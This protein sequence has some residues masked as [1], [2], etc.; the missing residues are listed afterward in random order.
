MKQ[1]CRRLRRR[2]MY[3]WLGIA[4]RNTD[5]VT[6][7]AGVTAHATTWESSAPATQDDAGKGGS[8]EDVGKVHTDDVEKGG[9]GE[10][11]EKGG[12]DVLVS[13]HAVKVATAAQDDEAIR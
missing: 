9:T 3:A 2:Y 12:T 4:L 5:V 13:V 10:N 7:A 6:R 8:G 11:V 1:Q